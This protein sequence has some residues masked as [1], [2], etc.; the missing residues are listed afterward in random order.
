MANKKKKTRS[1]SMAMSQAAEQSIEAKS[2][3]IQRRAVEDD[4]FSPDYT[5]VIRDLKR[6]GTLA[7]VFFVILVA[8]SFIL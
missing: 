7:G 5:A 3:R 4:D 2:V 8:L 6:I 1:G